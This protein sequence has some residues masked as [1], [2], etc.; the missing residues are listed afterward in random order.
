MQNE[1]RFIEL[2]E[3]TDEFII[4]R[5]ARVIPGKP[6]ALL[7]FSDPFDPKGI[8]YARIDMEKR[9]ANGAMMLIDRPQKASLRKALED[10]M[11]VISKK[12]AKEL[13]Q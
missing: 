3:L 12:I 7:S 1:P 9:D 10:L 6:I 13:H 2:E 4:M 8:E 11:P 5:D